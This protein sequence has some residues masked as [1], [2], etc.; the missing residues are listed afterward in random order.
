MGSKSSSLETAGGDIE[1][2]IPSNAKVE[3]DARI[4]IRG[5]RDYFDEFDIYSDFDFESKDTDRKG[6]YG[7]IVLAGG[8]AEI[9]LET[10][11]GNIEIRK[12]K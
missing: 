4:R 3:I 5:D 7:K 11:N 12:L 10:T 1:L 9:Y 8:G 6:I 2:Y